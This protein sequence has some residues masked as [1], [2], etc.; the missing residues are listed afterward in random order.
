MFKVFMLW[1][2]FI[3]NGGEIADVSK[4]GVNSQIFFSTNLYSSELYNKEEL[5]Q[6]KNKW[7]KYYIE[8][9]LDDPYHCIG[10]M[11]QHEDVTNKYILKH[12]LGIY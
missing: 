2:T 1:T 10:F 8:N 6:E 9:R 12:I 11:V 7:S 5:Y 3:C 4:R